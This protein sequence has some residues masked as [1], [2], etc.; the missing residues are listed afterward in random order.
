MSLSIPL[1]KNT[2]CVG[3]QRNTPGVSVVVCV[4]FGA[5]TLVVLS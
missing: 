3:V 4:T 5:P 1:Q 2:S